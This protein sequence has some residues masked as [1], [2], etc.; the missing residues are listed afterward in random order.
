MRIVK[1]DD[2]LSLVPGTVGWAG[3]GGFHALNLA[4]QMAPR[5][6]LLVGFDMRTDRGLHWHGPHPA[7]LNNPKAQS[8][9]RWRVCT[10]AA[11]GALA[12]LGVEV[13][14]CSAV[15]ALTAYPKMDFMEAIGC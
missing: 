2:R 7:G 13:I 4:A 15:S 5:R 10:D 6:I 8:A 12:R 9:E 11:A 3:N 14:N 1:N